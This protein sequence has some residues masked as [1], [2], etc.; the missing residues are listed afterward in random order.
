M[1]GT[2]ESATFPAGHHD[3]H[4]NMLEGE[5]IVNQAEQRE[6]ARVRHLRTA[7]FDA[8]AFSHELGMRFSQFAV[9]QKRGI[10]VESFLQ[11]VQ[12]RFG[13]IPRV[14]FVHHQHDFV[15]FR[16]VPDQVDHADAIF[17]V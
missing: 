12:L 2:T 6:R 10:S 1:A 8:R 17:D 3:F 15:R 9:E 5:L 11:I 7:D 4:L 14:R 16:V 13:A